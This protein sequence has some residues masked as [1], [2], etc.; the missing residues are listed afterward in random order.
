MKVNLNG[1]SPQDLEK[2][3]QVFQQEK[4]VV[5][6]TETVYGLGCVISNREAVEKIKELKG[7]EKD[8]P[9]SIMVSS[10]EMLEKYGKV[11]YEKE[12]KSI[13]R[14]FGLKPK[15]L[16]IK[17]LLPGPY[18]VILS[19]KETVPDWISTDDNVGIRFPQSK[20]LNQLIEL[21]GEPIVSTSANLASEKPALKISDI[22]QS[23]LKK[24]DLIINTGPCPGPPSTLVELL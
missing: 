6:P 17:D 16:K 21:I 8:K 14:K 19:K 5:Y 9:L 1:F 3:A 11:D 20:F 18:T 13:G 24:V 15:S 23:I 10:F 4:I 7:R 12:G 22:D 2:I